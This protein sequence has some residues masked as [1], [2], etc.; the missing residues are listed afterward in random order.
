MKSPRPSKEKLAQI[1]ATADRKANIILGMHGDADG[2]IASAT[3]RTAYKRQRAICALA[4][5]HG[6]LKIVDTD[7]ERFVAYR[8][9]KLVLIH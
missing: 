7:R 2:K 3:N 4:L 9:K 5:K 8:G 1:A 6:G